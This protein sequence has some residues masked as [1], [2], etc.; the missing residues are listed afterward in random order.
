[1]RNNFLFFM[2]LWFGMLP[3]LAQETNTVEKD[4]L[5]RED[6]FYFG[7][8]YN[9]LGKLPAN[10][11]QSGFSSGFHL[12]VI[13]D[14]PLNKN[15]NLAFG[16]GLGLSAN[17]VNQNLVIS[18]NLQRQLTYAIQESA[19]FTKNKFTR[20]LVEIPIEFR[21]RTSTPESYKFWRI[22]T[23]FRIG[24]VFA[25][26]SKFKD[27]NGTTKLSNLTD[28]NNFQYG[29][30]LSAGYNTWNAYVYYALNSIFNS[31]AKIDGQT[32]DVNAIRIGLMFYIL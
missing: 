23:G 13:R 9:L 26:G 6:Q 25:S 10:M 17:S 15:R 5:Y 11:S 12:G 24:Y 28:F 27:A 18:E 30:S 7:V 32:I 21:W 16:I 4:S 8:T 3:I 31:N 2:V 19:S 14:I 29:V 20:Y 1:M 22:Y